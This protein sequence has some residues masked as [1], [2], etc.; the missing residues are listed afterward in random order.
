MIAGRAARFV[1]RRTPRWAWKS[2]QSAV[3]YQLQGGRSQTILHSTVARQ[4]ESGILKGQHALS[5]GDISV[6]Q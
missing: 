6:H 5:L 1:S 3:L 4:V 2:S